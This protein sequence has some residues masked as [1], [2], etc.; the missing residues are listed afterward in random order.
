MKL[1]PSFMAFIAVSRITVV[2]IQEDLCEK[3]NI[4]SYRS[5]KQ[6]SGTLTVASS[7]MNIVILGL[8]ISSL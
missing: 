6:M 3:R 5:F 1:S 8:V 2:V 7:S 4:L